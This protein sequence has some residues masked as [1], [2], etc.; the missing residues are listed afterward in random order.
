VIEVLNPETMILNFTSLV[1]S[2]IEQVLSTEDVYSLST[3]LQIVIWNL[4]PLN[5]S[6]SSSK[7]L[8]YIS[9]V[10]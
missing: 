1:H 3:P 4:V 9:F 6:A 2:Y 7:P 8:I 10:L 5:V